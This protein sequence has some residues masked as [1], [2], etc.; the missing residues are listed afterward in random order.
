MSALQVKTSPLS[1]QSPSSTQTGDIY[2]PDSDGEPMG[3]TGFHVWQIIAIAAILRERF[4]DRT[5]IYVGANMFC[6][7]RQGDPSAVFAPDVFVVFETTNQERR[8]WKL[9]EE[10]GRVPAI[11]FEFTSEQTRDKDLYFKKALYEDL[12][13]QEYILF[14]PLAQYLKPPLQGYRLAGERYISIQEQE[15]DGALESLVLDVSLKAEEGDLALYDR[16]THE[17]LLPPHQA[18]QQLRNEIEARQAVEARITEEVSARQAAEAEI[19]RLKAELA[20][21]QGEDFG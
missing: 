10:E 5:D 9:W 4:R 12:G 18:Y 1:P 13:V 17:K 8:S 11:I 6:Y 2:Y 21:L 20:R 15:D 19:A 14:D 16:A 7:Y 3:E